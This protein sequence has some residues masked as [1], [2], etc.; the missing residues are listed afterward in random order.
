MRYIMLALS[1]A[2]VGSPQ[3]TEKKFKFELRLEG[4]PMPPPPPEA[5]PGDNVKM[6][7]DTG[8]IVATSRGRSFTF[9]RNNFMGPRLRVSYSTVGGQE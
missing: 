9:V 3:Q 4:K 5:E 6:D 1:L 8:A 7:R 2:L